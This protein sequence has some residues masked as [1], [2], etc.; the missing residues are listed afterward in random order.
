ME[1]YYVL[2]QRIPQFPLGAYGPSGSGL[3]ASVGKAYQIWL[4]E[5]I[6]SNL[7]RRKQNAVVFDFATHLKDTGLS[8]ESLRADS[9]STW[10]ERSGRRSPL[11]FQDLLGYLRNKVPQ[12]K[13]KDSPG[14]E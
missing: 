5:N 11:D 10:L 9:W 8:L 6:I 4:K 3:S 13:W 7:D 12:L 14:G 1:S 2:N